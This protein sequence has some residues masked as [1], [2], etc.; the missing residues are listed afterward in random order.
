MNSSARRLKSD[1]RPPDPLPISV[2]IPAYNRPDMVRRAV[3][4]ALGQRPRPPAEVIVVDDCSV[5]ETGAAAAEAGARV[6]RHE[7]NRGEAAARNTAL[8]HAQQPWIGL[9]DSDDEWLPDMLAK[10]WPL[11]AEH[12]LVGGA[13][14]VCG[15]DPRRDRYGGVLARGPVVLRSPAS[16]IYPGNYIAASGTLARREV[17]ERV[18]G[19]TEGMRH[20]AD[21]DLWIRVLDQGTGIVSPTVV[22][23]YHVHTGQ[24]TH[25]H[26]A[27]A[28]A[29]EAV[30]LKYRDRPWWRT[31]AL[32]RSRG[33][34]VWDSGR[35][36]LAAGHRRV[37]A[38][39]FWR[40][41]RAPTRL[42]GVAGMLWRRYALRRRS[43]MVTRTGASTLARLPGVACPPELEPVAELGGRVGRVGA[44]SRLLVNPV[45]AV[46]VDSRGWELA[47]RSVG[48]EAIRTSRTGLK[49]GGR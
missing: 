30:A 14:L 8:A 3:S 6:I 9:L 31:A 45:G 44:F 36:E 13:A 26:E 27:L 46:V 11:R 32:E 38:G 23:I 1:V 18:G 35:R 47:V 12:V 17:V 40:A 5:D 10:L 2:I 25:E 4:S 16:L 34:S 39:R 15:E 41:T 29:H 42:A 20:G 19:W 33:A 7:R 28:R 43:S 48:V 22:T 24:V 21:M 49:P 37:A